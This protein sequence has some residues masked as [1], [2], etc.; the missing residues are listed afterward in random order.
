MSGKDSVKLYDLRVDCRRRQ[1]TRGGQVLALPKLSYDLLIC[2]LNHHPAVVTTE[3]LLDEVW[4]D[5][6]V[7]DETVKQRISLLRQA[8]GDSG[9]RP[10]YIESI[11][12]VG[13]RLIPAPARVSGAR[14]SRR[15][16][17]AVAAAAGVL[18]AILIASL[19]T[20]APASRGLAVLPFEDLSQSGDQSYFSDG[21]HEELIARLA[22]ST[23]LAV[24]SRTSV[25]P[26]RDTRRSAGQIADELGVDL[27]IEGSVRQA[28]GRVLVTVQ[29]IDA[30]EDVH[31]WSETY[32]RPL[33]VSNL[34][35]IQREIATSVAGEL[36]TEITEPATPVEDAIPTDSLQAYQDYLL[37]RYHLLRGNT[38]DL[39]R[40]VRFFEAAIAA[41]PRF[42]E[43]H[44]G[45]GRAMAFAG[46]GYGWLAPDDAFPR[47]ESLVGTALQLD[48]DLADAH[49][50]RADI[51]SWYRWQWEEAEASYLEA[52]EAGMDGDLGYILMLSVLDRHDEA[53]RM[54]DALIERYPHDFWVRSNAA[55]RYLHA[56][57][58]DRAIAEA[59]AAIDI[60]DG[61][62]DPYEA[63]GWAFIAQGV[64]DRAIADFERHASMN[65]GRAIALAPL[66]YARIVAGD[67]A[68]GRALMK[69]IQDASRHEYIPPS[70]FAMIHVALDEPD[71][72]FE[73]L[74]H[75][76]ASR[77]RDLIFLEGNPAWRPIRNDERYAALLAAIGLDAY[78]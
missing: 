48:P 76:L 52:V 23:S 50:L 26:Y 11:R 5:V 63:R 41:D 37:G 47:A 31:L 15:T 28:D 33:S 53:L 16:W 61:E 8:L 24:T 54:I 73:W 21:M 25:M 69:E 32:E 46:T 10:R 30:T 72:A 9:A 22:N 4:G 14:P 39:Q 67:V 51:L 71:T 3:Q 27:I 43:A 18:I 13:Y 66:A 7:S 12:G 75:A 56:G 42:A 1:V 74:Q 35:D 36:R 45:L 57:E 49:S 2:L 6:V 62:G 64:L 78:R 40:S 38:R 59:G 44:V 68:G 29:L 19:W 55:W 70:A 77:S 58:M 17:P 34:F 20:G 65:E 60:D